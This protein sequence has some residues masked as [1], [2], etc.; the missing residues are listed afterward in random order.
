MRTN[1]HVFAE[2]A[3]NDSAVFSIQFFRSIESV[4]T[5]EDSVY[6]TALRNTPEQLDI[7]KDGLI[8]SKLLDPTGFCCHPFDQQDIPTRHDLDKLDTLERVPCTISRDEFQK[9]YERPRRPVILVGCSEGWP[10]A[11]TWHPRQFE[12]RF[13][14]KTVFRAFRYLSGQAEFMT[15]ERSYLWENILENKISRRHGKESPVRYYIGHRLKG[16]DPLLLDF[17]HPDQFPTPEDNLLNH[18]SKFKAKYYPFSFLYYGERDSSSPVHT[19]FVG[20]DAWNTLFHG[21]KWWALMPPSALQNAR[22][23]RC[24]ESC[25]SSV[26]GDAWF[27]SVGRYVHHF[28]GEANR[29]GLHI[30]QKAG[31][32]LYIP[33]EWYHTTLSMEESVAVS[34]GFLSEF[35]FN[36]FWQQAVRVATFQEQSALY[37]TILTKSQRLFVRQSPGLFSTY[38]KYKF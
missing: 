1:A 26:K 23:F 4:R 6:I 10:A 20:T 30:L 34:T 7:Q 2:Y 29:T 31:E 22:D 35:N 37:Y 14:N 8:L 24:E 15:T 38:L 28:Y 32:T 3:R 33:N 5:T 16:Q 19:D 36:I 25:S 9:H 21:S 11:S 27:A 13:S 18:I 12:H 17:G